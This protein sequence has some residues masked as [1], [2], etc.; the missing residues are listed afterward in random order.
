MII[1]MGKLL[2]SEIYTLPTLQKKVCVT[3]GVTGKGIEVLEEVVGDMFEKIF[4]VTHQ[5]YYEDIEEVSLQF[6]KD[7]K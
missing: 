1:G 2:E 4:H 3:G 6:N 7:L 5:K